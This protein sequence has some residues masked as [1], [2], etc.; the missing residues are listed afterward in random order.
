MVAI[1]IAAVLAV[2]V[3]RFALAV[4]LLAFRP[5]LA[6]RI[7]VLVL[8]ALRA[9]SGAGGGALLLRAGRRLTVLLRVLVLRARL[10]RVLRLVAAALLLVR[11][12]ALADLLAVL[13]IGRHVRRHV[14]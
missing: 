2:L 10:L 9:R 1:A 5:A 12:V 3:L 11:L 7:R 14:H 4:L 8:G 13:H 6:R